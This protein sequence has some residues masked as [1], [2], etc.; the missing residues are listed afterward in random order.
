MIMDY[1]QTWAGFGL[2]KN[3]LKCA[4]VSSKMVWFELWADCSLIGLL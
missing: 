1:G 2:P 3:G 4:Q